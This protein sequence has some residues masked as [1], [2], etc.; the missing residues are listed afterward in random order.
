MGYQ[1]R[2]N[3]ANECREWWFP[4]EKKW[5][6]LSKHENHY[7]FARIWNE[8]GW[9]IG[10]V[11]KQNQLLA[12]VCNQNRVHP[13][14]D[15]LLSYLEYQDPELSNI[16]IERSLSWWVVN[17]DGEFEQWCQKAIWIGIV[18]RIMDDPGYQRTHVTLRGP[19]GCGKTT[20]VKNLL[21]DELGGVGQLNLSGSD[22]DT[23]VLMKVRYC[24]EYPE[25][26]GMSK[27]DTAD[28]KRFFGAGT[29]DIRVLHTTESVNL[30]YDAYIVGTA[31][32]DPTLYDDPALMERFAYL[33]VR[34][35]DEYDPAIWIPKIRKHYLAEALRLYMNGERCHVIPEDMKAVLMEHAA[36]SVYRDITLDDQF[37]MVDWFIVPKEVTITEF[38]AYMGLARDADSFRRK[39]LLAPLTKLLRSKGFVAEKG[40]GSATWWSRPADSADLY[41]LPNEDIPKSRTA[42][43]KNRAV[44]AYDSINSFSPVMMNQR[45]RN[46]D[47]F[48]I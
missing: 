6:P 47:D 48:D 10:T 41:P 34:R 24:V 26:S 3:L 1:G 45:I 30:K 25:M 43:R 22:R 7:M 17:P 35:N 27:R 28:R 37:D 42:Q 36:P 38:A 13:Y 16:P 21:P 32:E 33:D 11:N 40:K 29:M 12:Y 2:F 4:D 23:I 44:K 18:S 8:T 19:G 31:N 46:Q 14:R 20:L 9:H 39:R 5:R 15:E